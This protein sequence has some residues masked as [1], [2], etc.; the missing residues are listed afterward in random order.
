M[1][2]FL[3][4]IFWISFWFLF[5]KWTLSFLSSIFSKSS[6]PA[7]NVRDQSLNKAVSL[8]G[9]L[10]RFHTEAENMKEASASAG[11]TFCWVTTKHVS[12]LQGGFKL[13]SERS[14]TG[15]CTPTD[16][17]NSSWWKHTNLQFKGRLSRNII[18]YDL[19]WKTFW[20]CNQN[21][22]QSLTM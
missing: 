2:C 22:K 13:T 8:T 6:G 15:A 20:K 4:S 19:L 18:F 17:P 16:R 3:K 9:S 5:I 14:L 11:L 10:S 12:W 21:G 7:G 1:W